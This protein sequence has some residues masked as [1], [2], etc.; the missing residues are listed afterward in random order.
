MNSIITNH[1]EFVG[2]HILDMLIGSVGY[3]KHKF[4][5]VLNELLVRLAPRLRMA[6]KMKEIQMFLETIPGLLSSAQVW[7]R[8]E[9]YNPQESDMHVAFHL[10]WDS[11]VT[12]GPPILVLKERSVYDGWDTSRMIWALSFPE[13]ITLPHRQMRLLDT[14][15]GLIHFSYG[16]RDIR[17][18]YDE[19]RDLILAQSDLYRTRLW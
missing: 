12:Y 1:P 16:G 13:Y 2:E 8:Q 14:G 9:Q 18:T 7:K 6:N 15:K 10:T 3:N 4:D 17:T 19:I 5:L 11:S